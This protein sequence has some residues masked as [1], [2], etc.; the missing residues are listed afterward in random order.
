MK[1][2]IVYVVTST[3]DDIYL[4]QTWASAYSLKL[5]TPDAYIIILTDGETNKNIMNSDRKKILSVVNEIIPIEIDCTYNSMEKS[6][7]LKTNMRA[8][9]SGNFLFIDSDTIICKDISEVDD[10]ECS[11]GGTY[12]YN[13]PIEKIPNARN[14]RERVRKIYGHELKKETNFYNS[15]V[16]FVKDDD[17][18]HNFFKKWHENWE[19]SRSAGISKDQ[20]ALIQT[21]DELGNL[22]DI[23]GVWNCQLLYTIQYF[24]DAKILHFFHTSYGRPTFSP[25]FEKEV[26]LDIKAARGITQGVDELI[27]NCKRSFDSPT[28]TICHEDVYVWF[29]DPY[30]YLHWTYL[31]NKTLYKITVYVCKVMN[32][33]LGVYKKGRNKVECGR[34]EIVWDRSLVNIIPDK[35]AENRG[36]V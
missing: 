35:E 19:R 23:G 22:F 31:N 15:G 29:G 12:D 34:T 9:I 3:D 6:R 7:W 33:I 18:A 14:V 2:K 5:Y 16:L 10:F 1:T 4:E 11:I 32:K 21:C 17:F 20:T 24:Y 30:R 36:G 13:S 8:L 27:K 26:Y 25:F 28:I